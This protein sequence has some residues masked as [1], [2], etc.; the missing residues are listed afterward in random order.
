M[1]FSHSALHGNLLAVGGTD[2]MLHFFDTRS[3][4]APTAV[5]S[6]SLWTSRPRFGYMLDLTFSPDSG[7]DSRLLVA[8]GDGCTAVL[9]VERCGSGNMPTFIAASQERVGSVRSARWV[10]WNTSLFGSGGR[11]G[12]ACL[13]DLRSPQSSRLPGTATRQPAP[14]NGWLPPVCTVHA[15]RDVAERERT[16]GVGG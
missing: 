7:G 1:A 15:A 6:L 13:Y 2:G 11:D 10:P 3:A 9:D 12:L 8:G 5:Q 16:G 14:E 4:L